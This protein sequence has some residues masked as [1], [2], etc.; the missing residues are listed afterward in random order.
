MVNPLT[1]GYVNEILEGSD[2]FNAHCNFSS[3]NR[4]K[5]F[6]AHCVPDDIRDFYLDKYYSLDYRMID[7]CTKAID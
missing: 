1:L 4:P 5:W 6:T 3:V 2:E 7:R